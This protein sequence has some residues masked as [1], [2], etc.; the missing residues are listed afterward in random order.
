MKKILASVLAVCML[1]AM[2][3]VSVMA[4]DI[5]VADS[6]ALNAALAAV[7][8]NGTIKVSAG[9]YTLDKS[10]SLPD[11][12]KIIGEGEVTITSKMGLTA[13]GVTVKNIDVVVSSGDALC[14]N[15]NGLFED[16]TFNGTNGTRWCYANNGDVTFRRCVITGSTYG[17]HF[18]GGSGEGNVIIEK[19]GK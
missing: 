3:P 15:G 11:N 12:V 8:A 9:T 19:Q 17:V 5:T 10:Y 6:A 18:D 4:A 13:K 1:L 14:I 2:L 16:C 7:E